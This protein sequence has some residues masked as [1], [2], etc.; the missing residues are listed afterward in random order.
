MSNEEKFKESLN[1]KLSEEKFEFD[2]SNWAGA[3]A[4]LDADKKGKRGLYYLIPFLLIL[5]GFSTY[6][7]W[8]M[9]NLNVSE[10]IVNENKQLNLT[11][12]ESVDKTVATAAPLEKNSTPSP[13]KASIIKPISE[14]VNPKQDANPII[15]NV[16]D[17]PLVNNINPTANPQ[18]I[19]E[20]LSNEQNTSINSS[21]N[22]NNLTPQK[23]ETTQTILSSISPNTPVIQ[24]ESGK[25]ELAV[26]KENPAIELSTPPVTNTI[27]NEIEVSTK[28]VSPEII[29]STN[30]LTET[31][32]A[33]TPTIALNAVVDTAKNSSLVNSEAV[34]STLVPIPSSFLFLELGTNYNLGWK[35]SSNIDAHGFNPMFG[36]FFQSMIVQ[37][38]GFSFG[39]QYSSVGN[40]SFSSK[41]SKVTRYGL[42]EESNVT[43]ITPSKIHYVYVPF[44]ITYEYK[45][46]NVFTLGYNLGYLLNVESKVETYN[47]HFTHNDNYKSYKT[48]GY[49]EGFGIFDSQ[50][51]AGY[52]RKLYKDFWM[53]AEVFMGLT[54]IK[55]NTFFESNVFERNK[56]L[57]ISL[58]Y[59]IFKK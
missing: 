24:N 46:K 56:G 7:F 41:T 31:I 10:K 32:S 22:Q 15:N 20:P 38:F 13:E 57:K 21:T 37:N 16:K 59:N 23:N 33:L 44:K 1:Q 26:V 3:E 6:I 58:M 11:V 8:P 39:M 17:V 4:L 40:L 53:N 2:A 52:R 54:D 48:G 14:K 29:N 36:V 18:I 51:A 35:N 45:E 27:Q 42:G 34:N 50:I 19:N 47:E 49:T 9:T 12:V 28:K 55:N 43:I 30:E 5:T 25:T